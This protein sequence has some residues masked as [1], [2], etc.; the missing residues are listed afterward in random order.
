MSL[1]EVLFKLSEH[2]C[3]TSKWYCVI[4]WFFHKFCYNSVFAIILT[5]NDF[6]TVSFFSSIYSWENFKITATGHQKYYNRCIFGNK[7]CRDLI[8]GIVLY[9]LMCEES[10]ATIILKKN[11]N[12]TYI[13]YGWYRWIDYYKQTQHRQNI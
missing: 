2:F 5:L 12:N 3:R 8:S 4:I 11:L 7:L 10:N 13:M 9:I 1:F 6:K